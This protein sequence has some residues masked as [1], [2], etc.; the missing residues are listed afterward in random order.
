MMHGCSCDLCC[1]WAVQ[2]HMYMGNVGNMAHHSSRVVA[3]VEVC[4]IEAGMRVNCD[5]VYRR[6]G[7]RVL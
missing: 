6:A 4:G 1:I 3:V 5:H 2:P 7:R